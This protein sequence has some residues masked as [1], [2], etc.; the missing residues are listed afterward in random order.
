MGW[1]RIGIAFGL[2]LLGGCAVHHEVEAEVDPRC[3]ALEADVAAFLAGSKSCEA[4]ADC[5]RA[6][7]ECLPGQEACC[8]VYLERGY[9]EVTWGALLARG[10]IC[11]ARSD[12]PLGCVCCLVRPRDAVCL[13]GRCGPRP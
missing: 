5:T 2:V 12:D 9:D 4:D 7:A 3:D 6:N 13:D 8:V 1:V 10:E 11:A